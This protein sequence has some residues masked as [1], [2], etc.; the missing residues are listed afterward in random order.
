MTLVLILVLAN[1]R[2]LLREAANGLWARWLGG[3]SILAV[4]GV[5]SAFVLLTVLGWFG[6]H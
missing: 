6:V 5:A 4:A 1:R 3:L 2:S